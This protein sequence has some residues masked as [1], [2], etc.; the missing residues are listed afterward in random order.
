[1]IEILEGRRQPPAHLELLELRS[2]SDLGAAVEALLRGYGRESLDSALLDRCRR[3][4]LLRLACIHGMPELVSR[5]RADE[6][7]P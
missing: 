2:G 5:A 4:S 1:V 3:L 7:A 6:G